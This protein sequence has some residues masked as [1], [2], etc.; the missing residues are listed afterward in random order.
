[1]SDVFLLVSYLSASS[2]SRIDQICFD[3]SRKD[4]NTYMS[5][6]LGSGIRCSYNIVDNFVGKYTIIMLKEV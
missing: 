6:Y 2:L 5:I 1:V 4:I 3:W